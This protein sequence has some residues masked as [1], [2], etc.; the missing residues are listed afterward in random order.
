MTASQKHY[1]R[2]LAQHYSW[3]FGLPFSG[4]V[5]EQTELLKDL[6]IDAPG[7]AMDLGC[8]SGF[9]SIALADLGAETVHAIDTSGTL[10]AELREHV[11][12]RSIVP[13]EMNLMRFAD[14]L[15]GPADTIVCMGDTLTHL[16]NLSDVMALFAEIAK[17]LSEGGHLVLSWRDL[18]SP[19]QGIERFI[20]VR[21][22]DDKLMTCFLEDSGDT[23]VVHDLVHVREAEGW[24]LHKSSYPKLKLSPAWVAKE[25]A[26]VGLTIAKEQIARG[27]NVLV[28]K[29]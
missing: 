13:Y 6:G 2:L 19:P 20:P 22:T 11:G 27:M 18:S 4:K 24:Q 3:M 9:Q 23:V 14:L 26:S 12:E 1:E 15:D 7:I 8:G 17:C 29:R 5:R 16:A 10:L 21:A 25:L 28:A